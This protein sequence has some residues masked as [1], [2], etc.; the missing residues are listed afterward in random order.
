MLGAMYRR[1]VIT[2]EISQDLEDVLAV[3]Q[4]FHLD[5]L[6]IRTVWDTR[7]DQL[8]AAAV[9][10]LREAVERAGLV[11]AAV[12][13]P[14]YKCDI[15]NPEERREH[16]DILRRAIDVGLRLGSRIVRTFTFWKKRPLAE[17]WETLLEAYQEPIAIA[18]SAEVILAIENES[19]C[20]IGSGS[21]LARFL[22]ALDCPE[23][24][25][26]WDPCNAYYE[27][28]AEEPF[29]TGYHQ[30]RDYLIHVH[31]K[32]AVRDPGAARPR[33]VPLGE[34]AVAVAPLLQALRQDGYSG[35]VSL[36][37]HWRPTALD[38]ETVRLPGGRAFSE[39]GAV[40][41]IRCLQNWE[42]MDQRDSPKSV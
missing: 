13:P 12:A 39:R 6:E 17:V 14:V 10:R 37:T 21:D 7:V 23:A 35:F 9:R 42:A 32:D 19:S 1:S 41:T 22:A 31:L 40:A 2:D 24:R 27:T 5:G 38:E 3:A 11:V 34:G 16:L 33:L 4:A 8:D 20:T 18:R 30:I 26:L 29:P 28:A 36:E 15:D 25:A